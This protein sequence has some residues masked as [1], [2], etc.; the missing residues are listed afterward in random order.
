VA[1]PNQ[2]AARKVVRV[3]SAPGRAAVTEVAKAVPSPAIA[4]MT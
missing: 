2:V 3:A 4:S 1:V